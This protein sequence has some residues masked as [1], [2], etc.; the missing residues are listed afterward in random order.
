MTQAASKL[1]TLL[2]TTTEPVTLSQIKE[3]Y[4]DL[5]ASQISM[6]LCYLRKQRYVSRQKVASNL[7]R[8]R[9]EIWSYT[10]HAEKLPKVEVNEN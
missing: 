3:V 5:K 1:R 6:A 2:K 7:V 4:P 9:K 10:Y 8:G